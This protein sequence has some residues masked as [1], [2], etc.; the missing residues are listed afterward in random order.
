MTVLSTVV[1]SLT[2]LLLAALAGACTSSSTAA[3]SACVAAGG[4]CRI[5]GGTSCAQAPTEAQDCNPSENPG[6]SACCVGYD[7]SRV[8][9]PAHAEDAA[10]ATTGSLPACTWDQNLFHTDGSSNLCFAARTLTV[11]TGVDGCTAACLVDDPSECPG[12]ASGGSGSC[13]ASS[14]GGSPHVREGGSMECTDTCNPNE[15]AVE[16]ESSGLGGQGPPGQPPSTC[17]ANA[18]APNPSMAQYY[19]CPCGD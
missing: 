2:P 1:R 18:A 9:G 16:C 8:T 13:S 17:R 14:G 7:A 12:S 6:G 19:C 4:T 3:G 10:E 5:G 11:C 15:Y